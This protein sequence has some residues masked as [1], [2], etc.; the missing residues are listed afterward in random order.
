MSKLRSTLVREIS[1]SWTFFGPDVLVKRFEKTV[2]SST[3]RDTFGSGISIST[4]IHPIE[5]IFSMIEAG[6][7]GFPSGGEWLLHKRRM[8][9]SECLLSVLSGVERETAKSGARKS[10]YSEAR[11]CFVMRSGVD[12]ILFYDVIVARPASRGSILTCFHS[13]FLD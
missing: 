1:N 7:R 5:L 8:N 6:V 2:V 9:T 4:E 10:R 13:G 11:Q 3:N 12:Y